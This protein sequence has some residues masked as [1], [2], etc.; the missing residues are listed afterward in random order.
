MLG[1]LTDH[2]LERYGGDLR[3]LR[4][5]AERDPGAERRLLKAFKGLGDVGVDIFF[6]EVQ[7]AWDELAPFADRRALDA[8]GRLDLPKDPGKLARLVGADDFPPPGRRAR[9]RRARGRLRPGARRGMSVA[10]HRHRPG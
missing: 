10:R 7:V 8:A 3:K 9:P 2:L 5:E 6:R 4:D 1:D